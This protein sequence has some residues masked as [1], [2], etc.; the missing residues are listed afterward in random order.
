MFFK[1]VLFVSSFFFSLLF[2]TLAFAEVA[3]QLQA[4]L[5][6]LS[7]LESTRLYKQAEEGDVQAQYELALIYYYGDGRNE[8]SDGEPIKDFREAFKWFEKA[9][10]SGHLDSIYHFALLNLRS[11]QGDFKLEEL[12]ASRQVAFQLLEQA[13]GLGHSLSQFELYQLLIG[14]DDTQSEIWLQKAAQGGHIIAQ[15]KLAFFYNFKGQ[16]KEKEKKALSWFFDTVYT[17]QSRQH[18]VYSFDHISEAYARG[19]G[20]LEIDPVESY[21]WLFLYTQYYRSCGADNESL[22]NELL[23]GRSGHWN[24]NLDEKGRK[25]ALQRAEE[26][27]EEIE[28]RSQRKLY[29]LSLSAC[30]S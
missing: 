12:G 7:Y 13:A 3:P 1:S 29:P 19:M 26:I 17:N 27:K 16:N 14:V 25:E 22:G 24:L 15:Y 23:E 5:S 28:R 11:L 2:S 6:Q 21:A 10:A 30:P 9:S 18:V 20:G 8:Y 4:Y